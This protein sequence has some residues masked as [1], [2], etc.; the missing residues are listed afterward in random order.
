MEEYLL[1][2]YREEI[3]NINKKAYENC[4]LKWKQEKSLLNRLKDSL[5]SLTH[6][7]III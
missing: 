5:Y 3:D 6:I 7:E 1:K 2:K 4:L